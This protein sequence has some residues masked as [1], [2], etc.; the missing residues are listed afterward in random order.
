MELTVEALKNMQPNTVFATGIVI[1][2][3][4]DDPGQVYMT[5]SNIGTEM[6]WVAK[7]GDTYDWTIYIHWA[8][9][10]QKYVESNGDKI[11]GKTNIRKLVKCTD[12]AFRLYRL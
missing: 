12:E 9:K 6:I 5:N 8:Y 1:N 7:R 4:G 10:G 11:V 2:A 3:P